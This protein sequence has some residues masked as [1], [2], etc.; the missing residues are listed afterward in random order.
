MGRSCSVDLG[1]TRPLKLSIAR[2]MPAA[3]KNGTD[4]LDHCTMLGDV[5]LADIEDQTSQVPV[6][7]EVLAEY[8]CRRQRLQRLQRRVDR[9]RNLQAKCRQL[10]AD[11]PRFEQRM[12]QQ[13][14][15]A[16]VVGIVQNGRRRQQALVR[17]EESDEGFQAAQG[18]LPDVD[19]RLIPELSPNR[20]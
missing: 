17:M 11:G 14:R 20:S 8:R 12:M 16:V 2:L 5:F 3:R 18:F 9:D 1:S 4:V 10:A 13:C 6:R 19:L 15:Q 7:R